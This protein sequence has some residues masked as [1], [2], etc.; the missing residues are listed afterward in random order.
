MPESEGDWSRRTFL[1]SGITASTFLPPQV[2]AAPAPQTDDLTA[3]SIEQAAALIRKRAVSPLDLTHACLR[4]IELLN[5]VLNAFITVTGEAALA[6][7]HQA[8]E[9]I[10]RGRWQGPLHGIPVALKDNMDTA[11]IRTTAASAVF[12]DRIPSE[13]SEVARRLKAAGAILIGKLNMHEFAYGGSSAASYFGPVHNPWS[14]DHIPGGSS[15]GSSAALAAGLCYGALGTDTG[16]SIRMPAAYCGVVGLKPTYGR[17]SIRGVIPV[18]WSVD[19]AGPMSRTALD[20]ALLLQAIAGY[21][22]NETTSLDMPVPDYVAAARGKVRALRLGIPQGVFFQELHPDIE[23]ATRE[24]LSV[25]KRLMPAEVR[26][27]KLPEI[28]SLPIV[29]AEAYAYHRTYFTKTPELYQ[30]ETAEHL[31][32]GPEVAAWDYILAGRQLMRIRRSIR[33]SFETVDLLVTPTTPIP[34]PTVLESRRSLLPPIRNTGRFNVYGLPAI[35]VPCGFT[36]SGLPIGLQLIGAP[37]AEGTVLAVAHAY[38]Q[39]AGWGRRRP[40]LGR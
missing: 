18:S 25:L 6:Q 32:Q 19:H 34:P 3:L 36:P 8:E 7:A 4:R 9:D 11:G 22:P 5:P 40:P 33:S 21:D 28:P 13:D 29:T 23:K 12:A 16:G 27:V 10:Q 2:Q 38:E 31:R 24:A 30:E 37:W 39:V 20:A 35:S 1:K 14:L 26:E 17:V 15:G